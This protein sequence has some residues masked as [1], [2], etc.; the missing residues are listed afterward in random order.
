MTNEILTAARLL[1]TPGQIIEVRAITDDGVASGYFNSPEELAAKVEA[2]DGLP[3]VQGIYIT[4]N[5]V[6]PALFSRRANRIKMRLQKKDA[7]T[8]DSDIVCR[9]W[10][11]VDIDSVRPSGVSSTE[12]E[13]DAAIAT[14]RR[15]A[16][17][18]TEK[19]FSAPVLADSGNGA[20]LLYSIDL[21][22][23]D[24]SRVLVKR[25]L[26]V[27]DTLFSDEKATIDTAN[28]NAARIWKLYGTMS[29][30]GDNT[31][32]RP[33][34]RSAI[35]DAPLI[36]VIIG[37]DVLE[38]LAGALPKVPVA[39]DAG[40]QSAGHKI[41]LRQW[42]SDHSIGVNAEKPYEGGTLY[43]LDECPFSD[44]HKDGAYAIQFPNGACYTGC[45]HTS[46]GSGKQRWQELRERYDVPVKKLTQPAQKTASPPRAPPGTPPAPALVS[47]IPHY[48][49]ALAILSQGDP[50]QTMLKTF[51][52]DHVG[53]TVPA[54]CLI[55]SL[56]SRSVDN[57]KGL[58]VSVSGESG[59]GKS[60]TFDTLL[61]QVP[62]RFKLVG[63]MSNKALF[64]I[65]NMSPG[66]AI[67]FDD[68]TLSDDM[69]EILKGATSSFKE[70]IK[71]RTVTQDR[72]A[73]VCTIPE[74]CIWWVAK[75][76][77]AGDDQV[78]NRMLTCWIDDSPEQDS[79][80][81]DDMTAKEALVPT[82][83]NVI[84]QEILTCRAM[85][86]I[87]GR[88]KIHV[89]IPF[90]KRVE[91]QTKTNR[92]NPEMFFSLIKAYALLRFKQRQRHELKGGSYIS[93]TL[94]DF[95]AA[96]RL[97]GALNNKGGGQETKLT[98]READLLDVIYRRGG[99]EF[100]IQQLQADIHLSYIS[101]HKTLHGTQSHG[102]VYNGLLEKCP[103]IS[104]SDRTI[105]MEEEI[106]RSVRR[107][108]NAY[109]FDR[110]SYRLWSSGGSV[111]LKPENPNDDLNGGMAEENPP[112]A[113]HVATDGSTQST[114]ILP[115]E[116][117]I[118]NINLC[119]Y[120]NGVKSELTDSPVS[121]EP[122][123]S[124]SVSV[125]R[126]SAIE[127]S[128][129]SACAPISEIP[130]ILPNGNGGRCC[131][132]PEIL[133]HSA[134]GEPVPH[135][136]ATDYKPLD[137]PEPHVP[138]YCCRKK[139]SWYV[140]KLTA[141]RKARPKDDQAARRVCRKC[142]DIAVRRDRA[143]AP[144][145]PGMIDLH[146]MERHSPNIGKCSICNLGAATYLNKETGVKLCEPC[147]TR[148]VQR[149]CSSSEVRA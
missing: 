54:E 135:V 12:E 122:A 21:P 29:R 53:D 24:A 76:E 119:T 67:V 62:E 52:L 95:Y 77:G 126:V 31:S 60:G 85:W 78:F 137:I 38:R 57:T 93:A 128:K 45:H 22:N 147:H 5:P 35:I 6:N 92:R 140:E 132:S 121:A 70:P 42:L 74:R 87:I 17:F 66:T 130:P 79:A 114:E 105:V 34:R 2:L 64:Y 39:S 8:A 32:D 18:L 14:A 20:H 96:A 44:A 84:R 111:W 112:M 117:T 27:L 115:N 75:V 23:D 36:P 16:A 4:L 1:S 50:L 103:A 15:V 9:Q 118:N 123:E 145:L 124:G 88:E 30:K 59:K 47:D 58:H 100:T 104:F 129:T 13:H 68:K 108:T 69:Q 82:E 89:V 91:F 86:E 65:S 116:A 138:C 56:A 11:P 7:T 127:A 55:V 144:P 94:D 51:S 125:I 25:C 109:Q 90:A 28:F 102:I 3:T 10:L 106:G 73:Q 101:I 48:A 134:I 63:A 146:G 71:Y 46:C 49:E 81:L 80:V 97:F 141:E 133:R 120:C 113:E 139:G 19:G 43:Q 131:K 99:A 72:Q 149:Q 148:E 142:Y 41:V 33:H 37:Q 110:E 107:R 136:H 98:K 40:N 143:A 83:L 61:L 26:D